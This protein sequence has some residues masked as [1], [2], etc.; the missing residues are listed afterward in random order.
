VKTDDRQQ[1]ADV[2]LRAMLRHRAQR[3]RRRTLVR[4]WIH[5]ILADH[6]RT[7]KTYQIGQ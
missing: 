7:R 6:G 4:N 5:A 1:P 3:V 2:Q